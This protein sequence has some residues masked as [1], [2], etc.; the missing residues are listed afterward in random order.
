MPAPL[1]FDRR[2][3]A[4]RRA[5]A[6][7]APADFLLRH[8][9]ADMAD[10]LTTILR[11]FERIVEIG[12]LSTVLRD[13]VASPGVHYVRIGPE[14][15]RPDIVAEEEAVPLAPASA[16]LALSALSL[17]VVN[18]V[19][20]A[21]V[22]IRR[23]LRADG[24]FLGALLGGDTLTELRQAFTQAEAEM[25]GGAS[26]RV[27]PFGDVRDLGAL[28]QRAG[29]ALPVADSDAL[30]VRYRDVFALMADLRAMGGTNVLASRRRTPTRRATMLR[31][32]GIYAERFSDPDGRIRA[33][34]EIV[35]LSGWAPHESQQKPLK[36]GSARTRLSDALRPGQAR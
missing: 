2:V 16:D 34:F 32:A 4:L 17:Q 10:R 22:Q 6:A 21:L 27:S 29:F 13:A 14:D 18:D 19:P 7:A 30:T 8:V 28:L 26:P 20:G 25:E 1:L 24:L 5:R 3:L 36:P 33:T 31:M 23:T 11:P 35:H 15:A 12:S 9:A